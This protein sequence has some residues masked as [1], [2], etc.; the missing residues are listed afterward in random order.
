MAE[1]RRWSVTSARRGVPSPAIAAGVAGAAAVAV[2]AAVV[3]DWRL[4]VP[5]ALGLPI[6]GAVT[7]Q[8]WAS[9]NRLGPVVAD[10]TVHRVRSLSRVSV[11]HRDATL[12]ATWAGLVLTPGLRLFEGQRYVGEASSGTGS[13]DIL[14]ELAATG[15]AALVVVSALRAGWSIRLPRPTSLLAAFALLTVLSVIWSHL[16]VFSAARAFQFATLA[17]FTAYCADRAAADQ[18][19]FERILER[20]MRWVTFGVLALVVWAFLEGGE[21][22]G[23]FTWR[24]SHPNNSASLMLFPALALVFH[25]R[26]RE[27][28]R[29]LPWWLALG[30]LVYF[31]YETGAR[32]Y[33]AAG[34]VA[35]FA[36]WLFTGLRDS[37][38]WA[39]GLGVGLIVAGT[40]WGFAA[41]RV[42]DFIYRDNSSEEIVSLHGRRELWAWALDN[43]V[44]SEIWGIGVG[45][46]RGVINAPWKPQNAH[47]A[48]I[49]LLQTV[50]VVGITLMGALLA[51]LL[52]LAALRRSVHAAWMTAFVVVAS[53]NSV[54]IANPGPITVVLGLAILALQE[55][56]APPSAP[57]SS[58]AAT[59][60]A[61]SGA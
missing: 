61:G 38:R 17:A 24:G 45:A 7:L 60:R 41:D 49:D 21:W 19:F 26:R 1:P 27:I 18:G 16:P 51:S 25:P 13:I 48:W 29:P 52:A 20:T 43:P 9:P 55:G 32:G 23:R 3:L 37:R 5:V 30:V 31:T 57:S 58:P 59:E 2:L 36:G 44:G 47:N 28:T 53:V 56:R 14:L 22:R 50:G 11:L 33:A 54:T 40:I 35:L 4:A 46:N 12:A 6:V 15:L 39:L 34:A 42:V 8:E 10:D